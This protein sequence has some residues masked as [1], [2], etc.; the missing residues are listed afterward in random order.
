M[1]IDF[2]E[3]FDWAGAVADLQLRWGVQDTANVSLITGRQGGSTQAIRFA[4]VATTT[5]IEKAQ[6]Q[7]SAFDDTHWIFGFAIRINALPTTRSPIFVQTSS[8]RNDFAQLILD[9]AG[10]MHWVA[11]NDTTPFLAVSGITND[12][13]QLNTWQYIEIEHDVRDGSGTGQVTIR[14]D[15]KISLS[16]VTGTVTIEEDGASSWGILKTFNGMQMDVDD[17]Y[18]GNLNEGSLNL[19]LLG[20]TNIETLFPS[21]DGA[22]NAWSFFGGISR[23]ESVDEGLGVSHDGDTTYIHSQ[24]QGLRHGGSLYGH[25]QRRGVLRP[26][27]LRREEGELRW[28]RG[29]GYDKAEL[30]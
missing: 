9:Q 27:Q 22:T 2:V 29:C 16:T 5:R 6:G 23:W 12:R 28:S 1:A 20:D 15:G 13:L 17:I 3:G 7:Y 26:G 11:D 14:I 4:S 24:S 18:F 10:F 8:R 30:S 21:A 25:D 19:A